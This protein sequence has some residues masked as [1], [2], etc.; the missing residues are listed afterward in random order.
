MPIA[1]RRIIKMD[2]MFDFIL[3]ESVCALTPHLFLSLTPYQLWNIFFRYQISIGF[4]QKQAYQ[5]K[6][7]LNSQQNCTQKIEDQEAHFHGKIAFICNHDIKIK[8]NNL[9]IK[10]YGVKS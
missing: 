8:S 1:Q 7:I 5:L 3:M 9:I 4:I 2:K 10:V 6:N